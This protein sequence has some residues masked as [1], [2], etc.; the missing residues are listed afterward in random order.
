[1]LPAIWFIL[2][3]A[4]CDQAA[5]TAGLGPPL[6]SAEE[7]AAVAAELRDLS[8]EQPEAVRTKFV[9]ALLRGVAAHHAGCLPGWKGLVERCFQRGLVKLVFA[10]G[11]L[12]AG[13]NMPARTTVISSLSRRTDDGIALLP[14]NELLQMAGRAGRRGYDTQGNCIVLPTRFEGA[15]TGARIIAAGPEPLA[16]RF[17]TSYGMVLNLLSAYTLEQAREFLSRSF[18]QYL[19][20]AANARQLQEGQNELWLALALS[21]PAAAGLTGPQLAAYVGALVCAEVIRRP[22]SVW[23]PY[24]V[25]PEV[26]AAIEALEPAREAL[27]EAQTAAG[28]ARWNEALLVDLRFAG[29]PPPSATWRC[30]APRLG[31]YAS[32]ARRVRGGVVGGLDLDDGDLARLLARTADVLRQARFLEGLLPYLAAPARAALRGMDRSPI[33]DLAL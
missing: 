32:R 28:M 2:S 8:A 10:T 29:A 9:P 23:S 17:A 24:Q 22:M 20:G 33:S 18:G 19:S 27:F 21:H 15:E 16:S 6:T 30:E 14:H 26:M 7:Q 13:I 1:M 5:L 11:T 25:S 4:G 3:R 31:C 12:A